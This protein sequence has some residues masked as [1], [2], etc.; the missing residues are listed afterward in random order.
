LTQEKGKMTITNSNRAYLAKMLS[1]G[2]RNQS[3][4]DIAK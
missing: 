4:I 1:R 3:A 2:G